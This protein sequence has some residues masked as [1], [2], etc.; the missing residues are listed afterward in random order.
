MQGQSSILVSSS[1][2]KKEILYAKNKSDFNSTKAL[3]L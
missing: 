2:D 1:K 3:Q